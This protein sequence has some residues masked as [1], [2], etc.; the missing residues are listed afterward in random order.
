[1]RYFVLLSDLFYLLKIAIVKN[2]R[3][4][5]R[6]RFKDIKRVIMQV[7]FHLERTCDAGAFLIV[8]KA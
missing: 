8:N 5:D 2:Y 6:R 1:M 4:L 3:F 7:N